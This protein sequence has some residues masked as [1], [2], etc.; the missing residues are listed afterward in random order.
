MAQKALTFK[1]YRAAD[2]TIF[3]VILCALEGVIGVAANAWFP[4]Q[5][6][7]VTLIYALVCL[8]FM[9]WGA[10]GV[11]HAVLGGITYALA[12]GGDAKQYLIYGVGNAFVALT[13]LYVHFVGRERI[14]K[15]IWLTIAHVLL[16]YLA[17]V[18]GRTLMSLIFNQDVVN[19]FL[20]FAGTDVLSA[21]IGLVIVLI[22]RR[23]N[24]LYE[25]QKAYLT[26]TQE[27]RMKEIRQ[28][29]VD[30][31]DIYKQYPFL[32]KPD[33]QQKNEDITA[34]NGEQDSE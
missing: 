17:I 6:F 33:E 12:N 10:F 25:D 16:T 31:D 26:R 24:G 29:A 23:Q 2:L 18:I 32:K 28:S 8:V 30:E 27:Q 1:Q 20:A 13:I 15:N 21:V 11:I 14:R 22:C 3:A 7:T 19:L 5:F 9:R 34:N 4:E